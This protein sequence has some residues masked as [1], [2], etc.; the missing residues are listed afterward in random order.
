VGG[1][2]LSRIVDRW[3]GDCDYRL[4]GQAP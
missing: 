4:A 3:A 2:L 1:L